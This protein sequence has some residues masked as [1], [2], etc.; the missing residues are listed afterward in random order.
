MGLT[1]AAIVGIGV[2]SLAVGAGIG[3]GA[4]AYHNYRVSQNEKNQQ[5]QYFQNLKDMQLQN[6]RIRARLISNYNY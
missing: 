4:V 5:L 3:G 2:G 6:R 1:T